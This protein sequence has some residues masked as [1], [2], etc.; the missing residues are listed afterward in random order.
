VKW[1]G[2]SSIWF[3]KKN[4]TIK[5]DQE[6]EVVEGWGAQKKYCFK[7]NYIDHSH[8]RNICCARLWGQVTKSRS[9][10]PTYF[11][12]LINGGAIDGFPCIIMLNDKFHGLYTWN[13]PKDGWMMGM[14]EGNHEAIVCADPN[15]EEDKAKTGFRTTI[16]ELDKEFSLEYCPD[17]NNTGWI[18]ESLNT[19]ITACMNSDGTNLDTTIAQYLDWDSA[20]DSYIFTV[21]TSG[22]DNVVRNYLLA[23]YDGVKWYFVQYDLDETFGQIGSGQRFK[24]AFSHFQGRRNRKNLLL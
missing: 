16:A 23:T 20:I 4:Y 24:D 14:G 2:S 3:P 5:F 12:N 8:A 7:A 13:I 10:V 22:H 6:F 1:Q 18:V 19:L 11:A 17:E 9:V 21:L 15:T